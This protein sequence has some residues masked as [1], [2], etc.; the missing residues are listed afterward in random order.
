MLSLIGYSITFSLK[1]LYRRFHLVL[2]SVL[3]MCDLFATVKLPS[4]VATTIPAYYTIRGVKYCKRHV[5]RLVQ[6]LIVDDSV[7]QPTQHR[8]IL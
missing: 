3:L 4:I 2:F 1:I 6:M 8:I 5:N 7:P